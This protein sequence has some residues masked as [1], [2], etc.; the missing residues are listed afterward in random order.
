MAITSPLQA[1]CLF[2][3]YS[4]LGWSV[5][6]AFH[7]VSL[8]KLVN[9]GFLNGPVCPIYGQTF[10]HYIRSFLKPIECIFYNIDFAKP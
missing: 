7:A 3:V 1:L 4:F 10:T 8:G 6:V 5:E 9:R 2:F